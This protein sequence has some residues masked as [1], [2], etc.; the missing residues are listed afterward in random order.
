MSRIIHQIG[1][2]LL[3]SCLVT[4]TSA[5]AQVAD[6]VAAVVNERVI[7][8]SEVQREVEPTE[9]QYRSLYRGE[10][11]MTKVKEARNNAL[12]SLI[13]R[14][15]IIDAFDKMG[16]S[17]PDSVID[18][19]VEEIIKN[20]YDRNRSAFTKTLQANGVTQ[21]QFRE[22]IKEQL[23]VQIMRGRNIPIINFVSPYKIEE[24]YHR[25]LKDFSI[26][27]QAEV[28]VIYLSRNP[29]TEEGKPDPQRLLIEELL[30]KV[31]TGSDFAELARSYSEAPQRSEGGLV[32]WVTDKTLRK[33]L[34]DVVFKL[35]PGQISNV[36]ETEDGYYILSVDEIK[37][38]SVTSLA[39]VKKQIE[40]SLI[41][42]KREEAQ[43]KWLD[44]LKAKS[45]V[46]KL[47]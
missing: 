40:Q 31:Q 12:Q 6:G 28:R 43:K 3:V 30:R 25:N 5:H 20:R 2:T 26:P 11:L 45:Y 34:S 27:Q 44:S 37:R 38:P 7:T 23:I 24:Y 10:E 21:T 39:D 16:A 35:Q 8:F 47:F 13:E 15:L 46:K 19:K 4:V 17:L 22:Q 1:W 33:E 41:Q 14:E 32:G 36:V 29:N 42:E 18:E 9:A